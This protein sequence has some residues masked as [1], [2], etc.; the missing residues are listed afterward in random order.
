MASQFYT[1]L[2]QMEADPNKPAADKIIYNPIGSSLDQ[3]AQSKGYANAAAA[4]AAGYSMVDAQAPGSPSGTTT[5]PTTPTT[6]NI[7]IRYPSSE[8]DEYGNLLK[9]RLTGQK[10]EAEIQAEERQRIQAQIDS[11]ENYWS[12]TVLPELQQEGQVRLGQSR[13]IQGVGGLMGT[14]MGQAQTEK[15]KAY[16]N[17]LTRAER[18]KVDA[19]IASLY[20]KADSRAIDRAEKQATLLRQDQDAYYSYL[21]KQQDEAR[22]DLETMFAG[23]ITLDDLKSKDPERYKQLLENAGIKDE[24]MAE[25]IYNSNAPSAAKKD[26]KYQTVGDKVVGY[27]YD[28][29]TGGIKTI[30]S[31]PIAG[32]S[33]DGK[34]KT[35]VAGGTMLLI[36]EK[37]DPNK[38]IESQIIQYGKTGQFRTATGGG[39]NKSSTTD[40]ET[41]DFNKDKEDVVKKLATS[42][43]TWA[44]AYDT[45]LG[46]YGQSNPE[47]FEQLDADE[48]TERGGNPDIDENY[49][50]IIL[51]KQKYYN[52]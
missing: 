18:A 37:F 50:D 35:Q 2:G 48:I 19:Q 4:R 30:E 29:A 51:N 40:K 3:A 20:D 41:E 5:I 25:A 42:K 23:G 15:T 16:T 13:A 26:I 43:M 32:L 31:E 9:G 11:L 8:T 21:S 38:S 47:L 52:K 6:P 10:T 27:Y 14:P 49:I 45:L 44:Q 33:S 28:D 34:Y 1:S 12:N 17:Q 36:P 46:L 22:A 24:F 7:P 39:G